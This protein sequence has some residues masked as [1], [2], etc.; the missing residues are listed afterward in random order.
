MTSPPERSTYGFILSLIAGI[1]IIVN[2][3]LLLSEGF[4][5]VWSGAF[6]W[7]PFFGAFPPWLLVI[8]GL[9]I[10]VVV[11][12]GC[13]L[14]ILGYGTLGSVLVFPTAIAS[15]ILGGGFLAGFIIGIIGGIA[16]MHSN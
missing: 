8:I 9:I 5:N 14:M 3:A 4:Y 7:I 13:I 16:G 6:P 2:T 11:F 10:G 15:L 1:L 12:L